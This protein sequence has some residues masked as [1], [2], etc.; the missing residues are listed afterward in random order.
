MVTIMN[1]SYYIL[2]G[3]GV[4]AMV[5]GLLFSAARS[6]KAKAAHPQLSMDEMN[7]TLQRFVLQIK[8]ETEEEQRKVK[9]VLIQQREE[10]EEAKERLA[11]A[12]KELAALR[13]AGNRA[14]A[15][16]PQESQPEEKADIL[17]MRE[18][19]RRVFELHEEGL[20]P[21][22]IAKRLGAG[23]GEIDLILSLASP[24]ERGMAHEQN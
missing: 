19:Y 10:L 3:A 1:W 18:R 21:D 16:K 6:R 24:R 4:A 5:I 14:P 11:A 15:A 20:S 22:E 12:E 17:A 13:Q 9:R 2:M 8:Q 7:Q 23:R